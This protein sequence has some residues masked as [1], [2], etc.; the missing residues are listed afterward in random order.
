[1][2]PVRYWAVAR[3]YND[4]QSDRLFFEANN[5]RQLAALIY[6]LLSKKKVKKLSQLWKLPCDEAEV[7]IDATKEERRR[8]A[9]ELIKTMSNGI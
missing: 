8:Q 6:N 5:I 7:R 4:A 2:R 3:A 9:M 1:M